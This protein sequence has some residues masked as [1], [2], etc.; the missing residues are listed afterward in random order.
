MAMYEHMFNVLMDDI[1]DVGMILDYADTDAEHRD[2]YIQK[3]RKRMDALKNVHEYVCKETGMMKRVEDGDELA[4]A[5]KS[6]IDEQ[7]STLW[8]RLNMAK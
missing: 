3:A 2:F 7:I 5:F 4:R 1:K 8:N 6:Y